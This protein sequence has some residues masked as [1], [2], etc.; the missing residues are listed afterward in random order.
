MAETAQSAG[1]S[2]T[3]LVG[4]AGKAPA[5]WPGSGWE[6]QAP[7]QLE[8]LPGRD[9]PPPL[10]CPAEPRGCGRP[11]RGELWST[12]RSRPSSAIAGSFCCFS[13]AFESGEEEKKRLEK[14]FEKQGR[15]KRPSSRQPRPLLLLPAPASFVCRLCRASGELSP[16]P[17][18]GDHCPGTPGCQNKALS[19]QPPP[20]SLQPQ[21]PALADPRNLPS[22]PTDTSP[23]PGGSAPSPHP[24]PR[25]DI[26]QRILAGRSARSLLPPGPGGHRDKLGAMGT[27]SLQ[28]LEPSPGQQGQGM[29]SPI[30]LPPR[31]PSPGRAAAAPASPRI[32]SLGLDDV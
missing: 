25:G 30:P 11:W 3:R 23:Q 27:F 15:E 26:P 28:P 22:N 10:P 6:E 9:G 31:K 18:A 24:S 17:S 13:A 5:G 32:S 1:I 12:D 16:S 2:I 7:T 19:P 8:K 29:G 20:K 21:G 14:H 4:A